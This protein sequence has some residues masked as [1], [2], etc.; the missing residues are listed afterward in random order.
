MSSLYQD[1]IA[2]AR[3]LRDIAEMNA[4]NRIIEAV[5]PKLRRLIERELNEGDDELSDDLEDIGDLVDSSDDLSMM[6]DELEDEYT[7]PSLEPMVPV[8]PPAEMDSDGFSQIELVDDFPEVEAEVESSSG[9]DE[10]QNKSVHVNITVEAK[11]RLLRHRAKRLV[12]ALSETNNSKERNKIIKQLSVLQRAL[13]I[14]EHKANTRLAK[15]ISVILKESNMRKRKNWL[16]EGP[17]DENEELD[18]ELG[19][20]TTDEEVEEAEPDIEEA[21]ESDAIPMDIFAQALTDAGVDIQAMADAAEE[22][23]EEEEEEDEDLEL[24]E[25]EDEDEDDLEE[26]DEGDMQEY[27]M[28]EGDDAEDEDE[29]EVMEISEAM[30]RRALKSVKSS[31]RRRP[32]RT[33]RISEATKRKIAARRAAARRRN[34]REGDA[35]KGASSFGGGKIRGDVYEVDEATLINA[36]AEELGSM[37]NNSKVGNAKKAASSFGGGSAKAEAIKEARKRAIVAERKAASAKKELKESNLFNAKLLY[38]TKLMQQHT[39]NKK[40]QRA[41]VEAMDNAKTLREAKLLFSSLTESL[42]RR[43]GSK[44]SG[45]LNESNTRTGSSSKSLR[46]SAPAKNGKSLDRWAVLAGIKK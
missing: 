4:K 10:S 23:A 41:I 34:I 40:Q 31:N 26:F 21:E 18:I 30:L 12:K 29:A 33:S 20:E 43:T 17:D 6:D 46:S 9:D 39:L 14:S 15:N 35:K 32:S 38:V 24:E 3:K 36:L 22:P 25:E 5:T 11:N 1:A 27:G 45:S 16:F 42:I 7:E 44:G 28:N 37:D 8:A 19:D 2:D 13:I